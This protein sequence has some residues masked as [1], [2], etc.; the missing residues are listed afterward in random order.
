MYKGRTIKDAY[1]LVFALYLQACSRLFQYSGLQKLISSCTSSRF[2]I[3]PCNQIKS[4]SLQNKKHCL[5]SAHLHLNEKCSSICLV[6]SPNELADT[7][8]CCPQKAPVTTALAK[9]RLPVRP[10]N[11]AD[12][13]TPGSCRHHMHSSQPPTQTL[14]QAT[15]LGSARPH[16]NQAPPLAAPYLQVLSLPSHACLSL[17]PIS[18]Q[19]CTEGLPAFSCLPLV[20]TGLH[21]Y[22][23]SG[24]L[25]CC[26]TCH[27]L[28][29]A[30]A[31]S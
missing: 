25:P 18:M 23:H 10:L 17:S 6:L 20:I 13:Q 16:Q 14:G 31:M 15:P 28:P 1:T 29:H 26:C 5:C 27:R 4:I 2:S 22:A 12:Q 21:A 11:Q 7:L 19:I 8:C 30:K 9:H 24:H 3:N